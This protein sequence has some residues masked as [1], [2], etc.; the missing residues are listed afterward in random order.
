MKIRKA[1]DTDKK[2]MSKVHISSIKRLCS[3]HYTH[4]QLQAWTSVLIPSV[5]DQA[6]KEK[7]VLVAHDSTEELMGLGILD[8]QNAEISAIYIHPDVVGKGVGTKLLS[9]L[10]EIARNNNVVKIAVH[11]T[12]NAKG[13]YQRHGYLEHG[14]IFHRLSNGEQLECV[15]MF[16]KV[17]TYS[18]QGH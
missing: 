4:E 6:L 7:V 1:S 8:I 10:E 11:S 14:L 15:R 9:K 16:K 12:L 18:E 3:K 13:F 2:N 5:Y 17:P